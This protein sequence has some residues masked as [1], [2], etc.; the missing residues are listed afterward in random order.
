MTSPVWRK[1]S[2]SGGQQGDCV[3]LARMGTAGIGLRDSKNQAAGHL[4]IST[5][6]F[7]ALVRRIK[8]GEF[9]P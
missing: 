3:E 2:R 6:A 8:T 9:A 4:T 5:D 1:S 7:G